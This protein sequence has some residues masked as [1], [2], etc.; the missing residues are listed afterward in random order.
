MASIFITGATSG[1]G[2]ALSFEMAKRGYCLALSAR[3]V[4]ELEKMK[5]EINDE[6]SPPAIAVKHLDVTDYRAVPKA[7]SFLIGE[8][9]GL[10]IVYANAGIGLGER[11]GKNEFDKARATIEVNLLGAMATIDAAVAYFLKKGKGHVVGVSSVAAF[12]GMPRSSSYCASKAGIAIYLESLRAETFRKNIDVTV[13]YPG[14]IDT[15][16]NQMLPKR[17]FLISVEKGAKIIADLIEKRVKSSTVPVYPW[18]I[19]GKLLKI[20]PTGMVSRL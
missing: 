6:H 13:L 3:S 14:Y 8:L 20:L 15:P 1:I 10:D 9:G 5:K 7:L 4:E 19:V 18:N 17:P 11:V 12:R 16:L 2:R